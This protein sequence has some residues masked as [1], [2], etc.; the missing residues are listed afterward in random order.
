MYCVTLP[1][2]GHQPPY[3]A[4]LNVACIEILQSCAS[5]K[6]TFDSVINI[7]PAVQVK[8]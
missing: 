5:L 3:N 7:P 8:F 2:S 4:V 1:P 6:L